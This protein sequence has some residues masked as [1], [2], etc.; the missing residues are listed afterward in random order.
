[1]TRGGEAEVN[2]IAPYWR[3]AYTKSVDNQSFE[4]GLFGLQASTYPGRDR[5]AGQDSTFDF[6]MDAQYQ[7]SSGVHDFLGTLAGI[8]EKDSWD[9]SQQLGNTSNRSDHLWSLKANVDYLYDKTFGGAVGVFFTDGSHDS[10]LYGD[11]STGSPL[12]DGVILQA[13]YLPFNKEGGPSFWPKSNVKLS[14]QYI[15]YTQFN[16]SS[17]HNAS[18][19]NTLYLEAW[20]AF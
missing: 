3:L 6:G 18:D 17:G 2:G 7:V 1:M 10:A 13:N 19:N 16:G 15:I 4:V 14:A 20:I 11:S 9:A 12:S 8:Y 5:S